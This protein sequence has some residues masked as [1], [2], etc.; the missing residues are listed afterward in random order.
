[1]TT[2]VRT[3]FAYTLVVVL[4]PVLEPVIVLNSGEPLLRRPSRVEFPSDAARACSRPLYQQRPPSQCPRK[5]QRCPT[6]CASSFLIA[7]TEMAASWQDMVT[8]ANAI[9]R[10]F[11]QHYYQTFDS[12][13]PALAALYVSLPFSSI[14][15]VHTAALQFLVQ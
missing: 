7:S 11:A 6:Q 4:V 10:Q 5:K 13:P 8:Q 12:N 9:A 2:A 3:A 14:S 15:F 1:M